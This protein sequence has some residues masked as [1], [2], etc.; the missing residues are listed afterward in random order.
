[1]TTPPAN[2]DLETAR[3][4]ARLAMGGEMVI[5]KKEVE[6]QATQEKRAQA[7]LAMEGPERRQR[8]EAREKEAKDKELMRQ[9][10]DEEVKRRQA[11]AEKKNL[12][13]E[14]EKK[15]RL[16]AKE[17][18][19]K[20]KEDQFTE[21]Q[22]V[23]EQLKNEKG[24][25]L[26]P[27]RTLQS[28]LA[29]AVTS[30]HLSEA[31]IAI[32]EQE[33]GPVPA[34]FQMESKNSGGIAKIIFFIFILFMLTGGGAA[35]YWYWKNKPAVIPETK[36]VQSLIYA[37]T[38]KEINTNTSSSTDLISTIN[39][40]L[41]AP[42]IEGKTIQNIY[43]TKSTLRSDGKTSVKSLLT[44]P[45]F[46]KYSQ[47]ALPDDFSR[48]V[49]AYMVGLHKEGTQN[50][51]FLALKIDLYDNVYQEFLD[52]ENDYVRK[53]LFSL[54]GQDITSA[55]AKRI[56][57]DHLMKNLPTRVL[58]DD[59]GKQLMAYMFLD[60]SILIIAQNE[61][62]LYRAYLAYNTQKPK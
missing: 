34:T 26:H 22:N 16:M 42:I 14:N 3:E 28:D 48:F 44:F 17:R 52:S 60:R 23:I 40:L 9:R 37:E 49:N 30:D 18:E 47:S 57:T 45:E 53:I 56:F 54:N 4:R 36:V 43:F 5:K 19:L 50:S 41:A 61:D 33:R 24:S 58:S 62:A 29:E 2:H 32:A 15:D 51:I 12:A 46:Q 13:E 55:S 35:G 38:S 8:R 25:T 11:E 1:M 27:L 21:S 39:N 31:K 6:D 59:Q 7:S 20:E 10:I